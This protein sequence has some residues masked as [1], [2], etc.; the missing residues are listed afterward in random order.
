MSV[1]RGKG[2]FKR[3]VLWAI[4]RRLDHLA[5]YPSTVVAQSGQTVDLVPDDNRL[6]TY[7]GVPI[8][9]GIPGAQVLVVEGARVLLGFAGGNPMKPQAWLWEGSGLVTE[10]NLRATT[11]K[12]NSGLTPVSKQGHNH[13]GAAS[14]VLTCPNTGGGVPA[15]ITGSITI[16][17]DAAG[18]PD[19]KVP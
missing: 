15:P 5:L 17:A 13:G 18:S 7:Q 19:L 6:G 11:V 14:F 2:A 10:L 16:P 9:L 12:I 4:G 3:L 1:D 8:V